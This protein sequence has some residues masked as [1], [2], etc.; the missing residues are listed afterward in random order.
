MWEV[1][2]RK[3]QLDIIEEGMGLCGGLISRSEPPH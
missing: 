3:N 2:G 1:K